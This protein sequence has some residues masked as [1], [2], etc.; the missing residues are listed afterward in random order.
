M[1]GE[2]FSGS[3]N[4]AARSAIN[5]VWCVAT[6]G[7]LIALV[8]ADGIRGAAWAHL[9]LSVPLAVA[10]M[11]LAGRRLGA[12]AGRIW[13]A[14]RDVVRPVA[15]QAASSLAVIGALRLAGLPYD[16]AA[17]VGVGTGAVVALALLLASQSNPLR[18]GKAM[19]TAAMRGGAVG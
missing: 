11:S 10:Y 3:G 4:I 6:I 18:E 15:L 12:G 14:L 19:L 17:I 5:A 1:I 2:A 8:K 7:L 9:A 13:T 16:A